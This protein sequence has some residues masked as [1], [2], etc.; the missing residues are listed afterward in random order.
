MIS[1][2]HLNTNLPTTSFKNFTL[3]RGSLLGDEIAT[4]NKNDGFWAQSLYIISGS[5]IYNANSNNPI[6]VNERGLYEVKNIAYQPLAISSSTG[7]AWMSFNPHVKLVNSS[8][9][10]YVFNSDIEFHLSKETTY[11]IPVD[12]SIL[13]NNTE[14]YL[15]G[16]L[17]V[18]PNEPVFI[19]KMN[20]TAFAIA[21][22][23]Q[24][25]DF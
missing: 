11:I 8:F 22:K 9:N 15:D 5:G 7:V 24:R 1:I 6:F 12:N 23:I 13:V 21:T 14:V 25:I 4:Y 16:Y 2:D 10:F 17:K 20:S 3:C 19:K 18:L